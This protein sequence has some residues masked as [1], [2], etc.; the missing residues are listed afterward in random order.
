VTRWS[1][2]SLTMALALA[3]AS[4]APAAAT[5]KTYTLR[6]GPVTMG[7]FNVSLPRGP[8]RTPRVD[9]YV[10]RMHARL[11]D[12]QGR[13]VTI[14]DVM[15]HH[16]IFSRQRGAV[17]HYECDGGTGEVFYGTGEEDQTLQ[18]P[19]GYGYRITR[20]DRWRMKAM[21]MSHS[22]RS[23]DVY[24]Q[25]RVTVQTGARMTP[26]HPFWL[27]A[28]GCERRVAYPIEGGGAPGSTDLRSM[29]WRVPYDGRIVAVG[30]HLHGGAKD[31]WL[32]QPR[33][34]DRRLLD[35]RPFY[36]TP[37]NLYYRA[38]PILHEPGPADTRYF[39]SRTGI[40]VVRGERLELSAAYDAEHPRWGVMATM[41]V[42]LAADDH[43]PRAC[44]PLPAD[45]RELRKIRR[46]RLQPPW[47]PVPLTGV[48]DSGHTY[49][50]ASSP[51]PVQPL[52]G[53]A[54]IDVGG[55]GFNPPHISVPAGASITWRFVDGLHNVRLASGPRLVGTQ[56]RHAGRSEPGVFP[57]PGHYELFCSLHPIT[58]HEVVEVLP[59]AT[60]AAAQ[61]PGAAGRE[62][63]D[64]DRYDELW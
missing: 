16:V 43:V 55:A 24:V 39:L 13:R 6:F 46:V 20:R 35:T 27:R 44:T 28:M 54:V 41:H 2:S 42:Y 33:C 45:R 32:S 50:I 4:A 47:T 25:Y 38:R 23:L 61:I 59:A 26:V 53:G 19:P 62:P 58:M 21:L 49:T 8:A 29:Q 18:L 10:V 57:A 3:L 30:G 48:N 31:M 14:R 9:G 37:D 5:L 1:L 22:L 56:S 12:G 40:P 17:A 63:S 11:V 15:L 64:T 51:F 52:G 34:G 60:A 7:A 36:G